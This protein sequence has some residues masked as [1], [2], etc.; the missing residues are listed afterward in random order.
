MRSIPSPTWSVSLN[1]LGATTE[2]MPFTKYKSCI[3][4]KI[5]NTDESS[6]FLHMVNRYLQMFIPLEVAHGT[7][8]QMVF[9]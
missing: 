5:Q 2:L 8:H 4:V 3:P 7:A 9:Q 6:C 1:I